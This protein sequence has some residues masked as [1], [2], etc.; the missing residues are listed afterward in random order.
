MG[1]HLASI[2][3]VCNFLVGVFNPFIFK[4]IIDIYAP[5]GILKILHGLF[6]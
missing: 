2:Q 4:V 6:L 1:L 3:S 5:F